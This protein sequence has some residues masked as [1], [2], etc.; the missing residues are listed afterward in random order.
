MLWYKMLKYLNQYLKILLL[1]LLLLVVVVVV[2]FKN[3]IKGIKYY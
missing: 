1:L 2:V 3:S